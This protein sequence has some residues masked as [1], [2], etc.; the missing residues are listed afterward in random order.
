MRYLSTTLLTTTLGLIAAPAMAQEVN[1]DPDTPAATAAAA[2]DGIEAT[3]DSPLGDAPADSAS[4]ASAETTAAGSAPSPEGGSEQ[5]IRVDAVPTTVV[6]LDRSDWPSTTVGPA[7]GRTVHH[8][9]YVLDPRWWGD[10][11]NPLSRMQVEWQ[12]EE[13]VSGAK[14][15]NWSR[16][17]AGDAVAAPLVA[18]GELAVLPVSAIMAPPWIVVETPPAPESEPEE[19]ESDETATP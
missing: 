11:T 17:N 2:D 12:L 10:E 7:D 4:G 9:T 15:E 3:P 14:A 13:A 18:A 16:G 19:P 5:T 1:P 8:P 6:D